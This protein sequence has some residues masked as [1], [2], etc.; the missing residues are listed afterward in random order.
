MSDSEAL[1]AKPLQCHRLIIIIRNLK[2]KSYLGG[3]RIKPASNA[4]IRADQK[5]DYHGLWD[6]Q[7]VQKASAH[8][9]MGT[10]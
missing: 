1:K 2:G 5:I 4:M 6:S 7:Y 10:F 8:L 9:L 3:G